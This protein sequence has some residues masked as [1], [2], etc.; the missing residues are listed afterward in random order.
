MHGRDAR[1]PF[2]GALQRDGASYPKIN[3]RDATGA[4]RP[5]IEGRDAL[6]RVPN[7]MGGGGRRRTTNTAREGVRGR[8]STPQNASPKKWDPTERVP[9][10]FFLKSFVP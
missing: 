3:G 2:F 1:A 5:K 7:Q 4:P 8:G 9:T 6:R 10:S